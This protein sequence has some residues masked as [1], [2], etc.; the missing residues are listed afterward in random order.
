MNKIG[1]NT[2]FTDQ[3]KD[4]VKTLTS[5]VGPSIDKVTGKAQAMAKHGRDMTDAAIQQ[6]RGTAVD[7]TDRLMKYTKKNPGKALLI[8]AA[9][10]ALLAAL[11]VA[12][13]P[14]RA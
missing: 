3:G 14:S 7:A 10:G 2:T 12:L 5:N 4:L 1:D 6:V 13:S 8:A 9:S 11:V